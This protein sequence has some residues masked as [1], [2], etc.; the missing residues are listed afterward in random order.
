M[1]QNTYPHK[2]FKITIDFLQ[3]HLGKDARILDLG[4]ENP[5]S[6]IMKDMGYQVT[7]T[8][9]K[10]LDDDQSELA[11]YKGEAVT[12]FEILEHLV[13]PYQ[14]LKT[15]TTDHL[16]ISV[17]LKLW[18]AG[19]YRNKQDL[20]DQHYHEFEPW[21]LDYLLNKAGWSVVDHIKFTHPVKKVG[22]RPLLRLFT[23]R[24]YLVYC[25]RK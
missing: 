23:P 12:A 1:Y 8:T 22:I 16:F 17:P 15:V 19:A 11:D 24:Y 2:R 5:L 7:N 10:D 14:V 21:Q 4:V 9:G 20:R 25:T 13:N 6:N 3:K 18:F